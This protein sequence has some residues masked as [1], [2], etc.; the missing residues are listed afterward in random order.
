M[1]FPPWFEGVP[2]MAAR[3]IA[4]YKIDS[5]VQESNKLAAQVFQDGCLM[6]MFEIFHKIRWPLAVFDRCMFNKEHLH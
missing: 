1:A 3:Y 5:F 2:K 4:V 6:T